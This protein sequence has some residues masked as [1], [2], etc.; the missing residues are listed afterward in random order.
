MGNLIRR[1]V[2]GRKEDPLV[3]KP[4][5]KENRYTFKGFVKWLIR[6]DESEKKES[7]FAHI[8]K[9]V[10]AV[11]II[12]SVFSVLPSLGYRLMYLKN[13]TNQYGDKLIIVTFNVHNGYD[14]YGR[15][16]FDRVLQTLKDLK[17][18]VIGL[19]DSDT[20]R[21]SASNN[22]LL[23]YL[24]FYLNMHEYYGPSL[25]EGSFGNSI[26]SSYPLGERG[27][28]LLPSD[29]SEQ[30]VMVKAYVRVNDPEVLMSSNMTNF[31]FFTSSF[32][33]R[34]HQEQNKQALYASRLLTAEWKESK[35]ANRQF[36]T[37]FLVGD[38]NFKSTNNFF[39]Q[40][41]MHPVISHEIIRNNSSKS[42]TTFDYIAMSP[43]NHTHCRYK[44]VNST[45][46]YIDNLISEHPPLMTQFIPIGEN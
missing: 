2:I 26:L 9:R 18:S 36:E 33:V 5:S 7:P 28:Y 14:I 46:V 1:P 15:N 4:T 22:D 19:Q 34:N 23:E 6:E 25:R 44:P 20:N 39:N 17:A 27:F 45:I 31:Y 37:M 35:I 12:I 8:N 42:F 43:K 41:Y 13:P 21:I 38:L 10:L 16:N 3:E 29:Q 24:S 32:S 30:A 11:I 40:T